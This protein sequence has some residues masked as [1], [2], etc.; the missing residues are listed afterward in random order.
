MRFENFI[1][2]G[3]VRKASRDNA[4]IKS[5]VQT[6]K[7]DLEFLDNLEINQKSARKI[8]VSYYDVLRSILEA[9]SSLEEYKIYSHEAFTF[10]LKKIGESVLAIKFDRF[11]KIR[12]SI[13]YYGKE[14]SI[15]ETKENVN[16]IKEII[17]ILTKKY[18]D[19][20]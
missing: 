20:K 8:M 15:E 2:G 6:A 14:I 4:L 13:N 7:N 18:L 10:F 19:K 1:K 11:R 5:L 17:D 12:N 16:E 9:I 3:D